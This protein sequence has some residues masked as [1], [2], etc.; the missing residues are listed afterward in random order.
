MTNEEYIFQES[1]RLAKEGLIK[2]TGREITIE[3]PDGIT[4]TIKETEAIH[5]YEHWKQLGFQVQRGSR[6]V[7]QLSIWKHVNGRVNEETGSQ[8]PS[9]M[10]MKK[11]SFF[12]A[13]Q[14]QAIA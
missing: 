10:F 6:A 3:L 9:R 2:Y 1:Q 13:S 7:T 8:E 5:T 14:V 11:S 12:S 4:Q